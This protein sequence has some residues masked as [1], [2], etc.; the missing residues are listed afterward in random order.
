MRGDTTRSAGLT[1]TVAVLTALALAGC[2]SSD[3]VASGAGTTTTAT[4]P[5]SEPAPPTPITAGELKWLAAVKSYRHRVTRNVFGAH[6]VTEGSIH[7]SIA[8][9]DGCK[10]ALRRVGDPGRLRPAMPAA[11]KACAALHAAAGDYR[12]MLR[13]GVLFG[14][15]IYGDSAAFERLLK[16]ASRHEGQGM[17]QLDRAVNRAKTIKAGIDAAGS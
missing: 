15:V 13:L 16:S 8:I 3:P 10:A 9:D 7:K 1:A 6:T 5:V 2:S 11:R 17:A 12:Q 4:T 14:G